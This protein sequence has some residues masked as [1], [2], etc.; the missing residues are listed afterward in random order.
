MPRTADEV[1]PAEDPATVLTIETRSDA[2]LP[3][4]Y[5]EADEDVPVFT[6]DE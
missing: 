4:L 1:F 5:T 6:G 2:A 3:F